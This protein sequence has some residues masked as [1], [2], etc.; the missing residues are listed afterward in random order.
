[1][2]Q[3]LPSLMFGR[4]FAASERVLRMLSTGPCSTATLAEG[5]QMKPQECHAALVGFQARG[6]VDKNGT[7]LLDS[8]RWSLTLKGRD[9]VEM[10][11]LDQ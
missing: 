7:T 6:L 1:M 5:S 4:R 11:G 3:V 8:T 10:M 2:D 9:H